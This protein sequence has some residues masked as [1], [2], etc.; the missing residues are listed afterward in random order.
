MLL[1][2]RSRDPNLTG[3]LA[4]DWLACAG[5]IANWNSIPFDPRPPMRASGLRFGSP[6]VTTRGMG[7]DEMKL[8]ASWI[9]KILLSHGQSKP[10][11]EVRNGVLDLCRTFPIPARDGECAF[12]CQIRE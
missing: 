8:I 11:E 2:L 12:E 9:D 5:I 3:H 10:I 7:A 6:A 1:D 4:A